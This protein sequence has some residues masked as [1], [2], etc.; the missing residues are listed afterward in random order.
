MRDACN[1][2]LTS[3]ELQVREGALT[4]Q[5][6]DHYVMKCRR[7]SKHFGS[8]AVS[9]LRPTDFEAYRAELAKTNKATG[10]RNHITL[11][12]MVFNYL[13]E[14]ELIDKLPRF[15]P[16]FKRPS[17][18]VVREQKANKMVEREQIRQ[19]LDVASANM[20]AM[21]LLGVN[22]GLGCT[23]IAGLR[24]SHIDGE[25]LRYERRKTGTMRNIPLWDETRQALARAL[26]RRPVHES[27]VVFLTGKRKPFKSDYASEMFR[28]LLESEDIYRKGLGFYCLRHVHATIGSDSCD[29]LAV[30]HTMGHIDDSMTGE[31]R[32]RIDPARLVK[33]T[34]HIRRWLFDGETT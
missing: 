22:C 2:F 9:D 17:R 32:E 10:L 26:E 7:L 28:R 15:G 21:I 30:M 18:K 29:Q 34:E 16:R 24:E 12:R 31:Y 14:S 1:L 5:T 33:V 3:K 4:Q 13:D 11:V 6:F 20:R 19:L 23:D 25:W 27:D 8:R